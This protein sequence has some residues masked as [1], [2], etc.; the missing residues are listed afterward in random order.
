MPANVSK[1][2]ELFKKIVGRKKNEDV[3]DELY[4]LNRFVEKLPRPRSSSDGEIV[5]KVVGNFP[6]MR[7]L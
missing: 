6:E 7:D 5:K 3:W 4:R 1:T 2:G